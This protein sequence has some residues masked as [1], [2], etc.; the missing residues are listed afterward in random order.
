MKT[1]D[2][3]STLPNSSPTVSWMFRVTWPGCSFDVGGKEGDQQQGKG[4]FG[5]SNR[6]QNGIYIED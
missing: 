4:R 1:L 6:S 3:Y 5:K 2:I